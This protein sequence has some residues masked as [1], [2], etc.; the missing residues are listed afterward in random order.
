MKITCRAPAC[1]RDPQSDREV[2]A[3]DGLDGWTCEEFTLEAYLDEE[4]AD[5]GLI[6]GEIRAEVRGGSP[7][8]LIEFRAPGA[9]DDEAAEALRDF[10]SG[11]MADGVGE[12]GFEVELDGR[13]W[14]LVPDDAPLVV[15][16]EDDGVYVP[17]PSAIAMAARD[18]DLDAL[19][20]ALSSDD[21]DLDAP[22]Q[23]YSGLHLAIIY[24]EPEAALLLISQGADPNKPDPAGD[25]P[26]D[27]CALSTSLDDEDS[28]RIAE[29]LL[30]AGAD[31]NR[32]GST[33]GP[34]QL[35]AELR[36][37]PRMAGVLRGTA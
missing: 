29:A 30:A 32:I 19:R 21:A 24:G 10:A 12:N 15:E 16:Q 22:H 11:Q 28:A 35:I 2:P 34:P 5:L 13:R 27:T 36:G 3:P 18:G 31:P 17:P 1:V 7:A 14:L 23:G 33:G 4:I 8:I 25:A 6:G 20:L 26:L 37:K 9:L